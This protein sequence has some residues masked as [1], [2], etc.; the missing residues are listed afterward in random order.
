[1]AYGYFIDVAEADDYFD[2]E[3]LET[4]AWDSL[5]EDSATHQKQKVLVMAYNRIFYDPKWT[6]PT[7]ALATAAELIKLRKANAEMAYYLA[8]HAEDEDER[9]GLQA[10]GVIEAGIVKEKYSE[11]ELMGL[12]VPPLVAALLN[13]WFSGGPYNAVADMGRD[14]TQKANKKVHQF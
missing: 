14:E 9:K 3:R 10:Q 5:V 7:Y 13:D 4:H 2:L 12:P 11:K 1:M 8:V 6:L